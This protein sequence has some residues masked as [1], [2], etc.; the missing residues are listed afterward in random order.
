MR[1][2]LS[3]IAF[4]LVMI[5]AKLYIPVAQADLDGVDIYTYEYNEDFKYAVKK[6]VKS[7]RAEGENISC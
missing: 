4:C 2:L 3:V 6:I 1:F 7:C 5:T